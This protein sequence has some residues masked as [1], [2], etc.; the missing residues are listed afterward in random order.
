MAFPSSLSPFPGKINPEPGGG[1]TFSQ[2][3]REGARPSILLADVVASLPG[4]DNRD[5]FVQAERLRI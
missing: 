2:S 1:R 3:V 4:G 5:P